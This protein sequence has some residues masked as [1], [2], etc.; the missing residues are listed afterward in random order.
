MSPPVIQSNSLGLVPFQPTKNNKL[1]TKSLHNSRALSSYPVNGFSN[2][3][4]EIFYDD[5][6]SA[7]DE[8]G[9]TVISGNYD[10]LSSL[11][12]PPVA[13]SSLFSRN[14]H[15]EEILPLEKA[16][17]IDDSIFRLSTAVGSTI[18]NYRL[19]FNVWE[20]ATNPPQSV[21][22]ASL[23][24]DQC[25]MKFVVYFE[26]L[27][28]V[29]A[30]IEGLSLSLRSLRV[31]LDPKVLYSTSGSDVNQFWKGLCIMSDQAGLLEDTMADFLTNY[32]ELCDWSDAI[33]TPALAEVK[34]PAG[35][36]KANCQVGEILDVHSFLCT[37][38]VKTSWMVELFVTCIRKISQSIYDFQEIFAADEEEQ[39]KLNHKKLQ[40][41][42]GQWEDNLLSFSKSIT[43]LTTISRKLQNI[44]E[45]TVH[46]VR[47]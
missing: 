21:V 1:K 20:Q 30:M 4:D 8:D 26:P 41:W 2:E 47:Y 15:G 6:E 23:L 28:R 32:N 44:T 36:V 17:M 22:R 31:D 38:L 42:A 11:R 5:D 46:A 37:S 40:E 24:V 13:E 18:S 25:I 27:S 7:E 45:G 34:F 29:V 9:D 14:E 43:I 39:K 16:R 19:A 10:Q 3:C 33:L 12:E 35:E